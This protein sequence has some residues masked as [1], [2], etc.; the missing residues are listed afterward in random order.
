MKPQTTQTKEKRLLWIDLETTGLDPNKDAILELETRIT[1]TEGEHIFSSLHIVV[2]PT[3]YEIA[4]MSAKAKAMHTKNHL[5]EETKEGF[6][7]CSAWRMLRANIKDGARK[8]ELQPAGSSPHFDIQFLTPRIPDLPKFVSHQQMDVS[9]LRRY[10]NTA[11]PEALASIDDGIPETNHRTTK[12]LDRDI[13]RYRHM[14]EWTGS[15]V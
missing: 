2:S 11:N 8:A 6:L 14:L 12:C 5:L 7:P 13:A 1:D 15:R 9:G 3:D 4:H 10:F